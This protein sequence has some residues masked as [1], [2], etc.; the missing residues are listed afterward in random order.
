MEITVKPLKQVDIVKVNGR[1][2]SATALEFE[3]AL[4][5]LL[6]RGRKKIVIDCQNLEYISSAGLRAM[7][8]ALKS[9]K[10]G[11]GN[12]VL[13]QPNDR[14][15]DTLALVGFQT[16]FLQYTDIIDAVDSF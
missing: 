5:G 4:K 3:N 11:G 15:R 13:A 9:A 2:D 6:D 16:L 1:I 12:V 8:A 7:L 10:N 14:V